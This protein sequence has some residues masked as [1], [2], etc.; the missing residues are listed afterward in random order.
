MN[1]YQYKSEGLV[2]SF[3]DA[4]ISKGIVTGYFASFGNKDADGDIIVPGA[5][6][7]TINENGPNSAKPRIKH[8][9]NHDVTK[10][11]GR[12][13]VLAEDSKGLYYESQIG[14]HALGKDF[15]KMVES[16]LISE[17]SI[18][19]RTIK[20]SKKDDANYINEIKLWE[21]SSLTAW[22]SNSET[23]LTGTKGIE[24]AQAA[25]NRIEM[26]TKA[27]RDGTYTDET[28]D[29]LEIELKQLQQLY[30]NLRATTDSE[31]T[32]LPG[33]KDDVKQTRDWKQVMDLFND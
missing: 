32:T 13:L 20:E 18:G 22:G 27:L 6:S 26:I 14:T 29:L 17:H 23:P 21:G 24:K 16:G 28:F 4:D 31:F 10:P 33:T 25:S 7:R 1:Q 3:K 9:L 8:L 5:F 2:A 12:V 19:F 15:M 11:L 30:I